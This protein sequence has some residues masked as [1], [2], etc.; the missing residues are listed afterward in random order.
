ME[1]ESSRIINCFDLCNDISTVVTGSMENR[2]PFSNL[3]ATLVYV[4]KQVP[5]GTTTYNMEHGGKDWQ[6]SILPFE[7]ICFGRMGIWKI[8]AARF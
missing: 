4:T 5:G 7:V 1:V 6:K 2:L 8:F 3:M